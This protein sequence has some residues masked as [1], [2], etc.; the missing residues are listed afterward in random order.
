MLGATSAS[1][2]KQ[3]SCSEHGNVGNFNYPAFS[4]YNQLHSAHDHL[5]IPNSIS[6]SAQSDHRDNEYQPTTDNHDSYFPAVSADP[7][8]SQALATLHPRLLH[9]KYAPGC[10]NTVSLSTI[11]ESGAIWSP[12]GWFYDTVFSS[13]I[14]GLTNGTSPESWVETYPCVYF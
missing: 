13:I 7:P 14:G 5:Y 12:R 4:N 6:L 3:G 11:I 1:R 2:V 10:L 9:L 8:S